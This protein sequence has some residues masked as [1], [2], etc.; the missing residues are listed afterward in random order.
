MVG[1]ELS[2]FRLVE[3]IFQSLAPSPDQS[4]GRVGPN[5]AGHF[6]KMVHNGIEYGM[7][8][9]Y[10]EGFELMRAKKEFN[11]QL[12]DIAEV[13][14]YGSVIRSWLLDLSASALDE[15]PQLES[16][17]AFVEDTGE[18]RWT[19]HESIELAVPIPVITQSLFARFRS[20]QVQPFGAKVLAA[21]R[22]QF[23]GHAIKKAGQK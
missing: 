21:L 5:G 8:Q 13:W 18:G 9:S 10:A 12:G 16:V 22:Q 20:R 4:Y 15:D 6:V 2:A 7:M 14:R 1:G 17:E 11:L 19:V 23:G 3:P